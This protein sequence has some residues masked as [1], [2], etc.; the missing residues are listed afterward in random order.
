MKRLLAKENIILLGLILVGSVT[1]C[2]KEEAMRQNYEKQ[3]EFKKI[4]TCEDSGTLS[5]VNYTGFNL[6]SFVSSFFSFID[7][8]KFSYCIPGLDEQKVKELSKA[9]KQALDAAFFN[10]LRNKNKVTSVKQS[11]GDVRYQ[12]ISLKN[13]QDLVRQGSELAYLDLHLFDYR[14]NYKTF[15]FSET[16]PYYQRLKALATQGDAEAMC[17]F[18]QRIPTPFD[19]YEH[20][21]EPPRKY[22]SYE[23]YEA[24]KNGKPLTLRTEA[25]DYRF[26]ERHINGPENKWTKGIVKAAKMGSSECMSIYGGFLL[27]GSEN[28]GIKKN[29]TEA[30]EML[31]NA[32]KKGSARAARGLALK[33]YLGKQLPYDLG[34]YVCWAEIYNLTYPEPYLKEDYTGMIR[35]LNRVGKGR[36][37]VKY[38]QKSFCQDVAKIN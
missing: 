19:G 6:L 4:G 21:K 13:L 18:S 34:K 31:I 12:S 20:L 35:S 33:Y 16:N 28:L 26:R 30:L 27:G 29:Q 11:N 15:N 36:G 14:E 8:D 7:P 38:S 1:G 2:S 3:I 24:R 25:D 17:L 5:R 22:S 32:A 9:E 23:I 10:A 37:Y